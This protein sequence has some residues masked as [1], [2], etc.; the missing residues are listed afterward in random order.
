MHI[1]FDLDG[2]V[3]DTGQVIA[4]CYEAAGVTPPDNILAHENSDWLARQLGE[5]P[6]GRLRESEIRR[7]K[8]LFYLNTLRSGVI[9]WLAGA[10]A[11]DYLCRE[12]HRVHLLTG[13]PSG[14][15]SVVKELWGLA[16]PHRPWPFRL[17]TDGMKTPDKMKMIAL[18]ATKPSGQR[19]VYVDD[20]AKFIDLPEGWKFVHFTTELDNVY[21]LSGK[22]LHE[23]GEH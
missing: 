11:A 3:I 6:A 13:A 9:D 2:V 23:L 10:G 20:Q 17:A 19:G 12:G 1:V 16:F 22:I 5:G 14:T 15:I 8:N 4:R 18:L 21:R 7:R